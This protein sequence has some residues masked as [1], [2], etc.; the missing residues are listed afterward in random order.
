MIVCGAVVVSE[1]LLRSFQQISR[2]C[3]CRCRQPAYGPRVKHLCHPHPLTNMFFCLTSRI[4]LSVQDLEQQVFALTAERDDVIAA[5]N[6]VQLSQE[7][8]A[9]KIKVCRHCQC[10][11]QALASLISIMCVPV[12]GKSTWVFASVCVR[13]ANKHIITNCT[14]MDQAKWMPVSFLFVFK[15]HITWLIAWTII[16]STGSFHWTCIRMVLLAR[17]IY[18]AKHATVVFKIMF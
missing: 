4:G 15:I 12:D 2:N 18:A 17:A 9:T 11:C 6:T 5:Y 10:N 8:A 16:H 7:T 1:L 13:M 3:L 14:S